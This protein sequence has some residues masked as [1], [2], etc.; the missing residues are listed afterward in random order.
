MG[1]RSYRSLILQAEVHPKRMKERF[2]K[3]AHGFAAEAGDRVLSASVFSSVKLDSQ[4]GEQQ[5]MDWIAEY[6]P[7]IL[8]VD[9]LANFHCGDENV[10]RDMR[11]VTNVLDNIRQRDVAIVLV[12]HHSKSASERKDVG[13]KAR[14]SSALAGWYDSHF[15]LE[16]ANTEA[17]TRRLQFELR[18]A[19]VPADKVLKLNPATLQFEEQTDE[20]SQ[21]SLVVSTVEELGSATSQQVAERCNK[22]PQWAGEYLRQAVTEGKLVATGNRPVIYSLPGMAAVTT[23]QIPNPQGGE[24]IVV[25][26]NTSGELRVD[27]DRWWERQQ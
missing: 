21:I 7:D 13:H 17:K 16:W 12:H 26:T 10:A 23:V 20:P 15:S 1:H 5:V 8:V 24:P 2:Q 6:Q 22:T 11:R 3:Q 14:G 25:S 4:E 18:H 27:G 19:E 9:P